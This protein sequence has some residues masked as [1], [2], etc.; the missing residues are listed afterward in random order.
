MTTF[1]RGSLDQVVHQLQRILFVS[2]IA[3]GII[4]VGLAEIHQIQHPNLVALAFEVAASGQ[5][6]FALWV[7]DYI[8]GVG[9]QNVGEH[10][11]PR[12]SGTAAADDQYVEAAAMLAAVQP[13]T[14]VA[15]ENFALLLGELAI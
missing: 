2:K 10:I 1:G 8:V 4:A 11:A 12:L 9:L 13:Q 14:D 3:K 7:G 6:Y 5:Q 15:G